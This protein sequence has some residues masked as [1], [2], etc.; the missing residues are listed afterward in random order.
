MKYNYL[1]LVDKDA[2]LEFGPLASTATGLNYTIVQRLKTMG[3]IKKSSEVNI[4][5]RSPASYVYNDYVL[6]LALDEIGDPKPPQEDP[7]PAAAAVP[8][9]LLA[10]ELKKSTPLVAVAKATLDSMEK[11]WVLPGYAQSSSVVDPKVLEEEARVRWSLRVAAAADVIARN[12]IA[13][14]LEREDVIELLT[15]GEGAQPPPPQTPPTLPI[16]Y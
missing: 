12:D 10:S 14:A 13:T 11:A 9:D 6:A 4:P 7:S 1:P 3:D 15:W 8:L 2:A 16:N 5:P